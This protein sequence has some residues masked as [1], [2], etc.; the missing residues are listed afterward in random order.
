M[1][2]HAELIHRWSGAHQSSGRKALAEQS[3]GRLIVAAERP[4]AEARPRPMAPPPGAAGPP[5][6]H[7]PGGRRKKRRVGGG[8]GLRNH[9][10]QVTTSAAH[11]PTTTSA[12]KAA[13]AANSIQWEH[14]PTH[15]ATSTPTY[16]DFSCAKIGADTLVNAHGEAKIAP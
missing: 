10:A 9:G 5:P 12:E 1:V 7:L 2:V 11:S 3:D 14:H 16:A 13:D 4:C 8:E 6:S 15:T